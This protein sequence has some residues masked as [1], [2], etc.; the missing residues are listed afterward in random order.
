M[1]MESTPHSQ[2]QLKRILEGPL[3][4]GQMNLS[5]GSEPEAERSSSSPCDRRSK[6]WSTSHSTVQAQRL[7]DA[8]VGSERRRT[9]T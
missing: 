8:A 2:P 7:S 9:S 3:A 1:K 5:F 6:P 4:T